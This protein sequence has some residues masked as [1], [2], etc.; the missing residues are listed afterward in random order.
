MKKLSDAKNE[1]NTN[2]KKNQAQV[3]ITFLQERGSMSVFFFG[4]FSLN[5]K[6]SKKNG[7]KNYTKKLF[8]ANININMNTYINTY[9]VV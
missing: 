7:I 4:H 3:E 1:S 5:T 8:P 9:F 2:E 6:H